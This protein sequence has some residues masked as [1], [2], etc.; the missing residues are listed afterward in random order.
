VRKLPRVPNAPRALI[1]GFTGQ[2]GSFLAELLLNEGYEVTGLVRD[3]LKLG[4]SEHLR[5]RVCI[6]RG[7]LEQPETVLAAIAKTQPAE[8]YHL[9]GPSDVPG[10]WNRPRGTVDEIVGSCAVVLYGVREFAPKAHVFIAASGAMFGNAPDWPQGEDTPC[11]PTTPYGIA[12]L[13]AHKLV[14]ATRDKYGLFACSGIVFNH[15]SERR[16]DW[17]VTRKVTRA[18]AAIAHGSEEKLPLGPMDAIRDWSFARDIMKGAW[19]ML[20]QEH[21]D[22]YVLASG[23]PHTVQDLVDVAFA[24]VGQDPERFL[25]EDPNVDERRASEPTTPNVG[26]A[27]KALTQLGWRPELDFEQLIQRMVQA[28]LDALESLASAL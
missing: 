20:Q 25:C 2:D 6:R 10:S 1:T 7:Y 4:S 22:D 26:D 24:Y 13:A 15:E 16:P 9:A 3:P 8:I 28:D 11:N 23:V 27:A 17:F 19:L 14:G 21:A 12:R 5:E 18:A